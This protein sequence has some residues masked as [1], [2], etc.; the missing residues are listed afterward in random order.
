V[1]GPGVRLGVALGSVE[2]PAAIDVAHKRTVRSK[3]IHEILLLRPLK[4]APTFD[5]P[6]KKP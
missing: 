6:V 2:L 5:E 1:V 3:T 4:I